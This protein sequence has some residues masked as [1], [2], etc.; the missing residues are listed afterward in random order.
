MAKL[1]AGLKK[2]K[3]KVNPCKDQHSQ[4][5]QSPE[6]FIKLSYQPGTYKDQSKAPGTY[7]AE[8]NLVWS[9]WEKM[10]LNFERLETS[11]KGEAGGRR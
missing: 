10:C 5:T 1:G 2:L 6:S 7:I 9:H 8:V 3:E 11:G 4:L